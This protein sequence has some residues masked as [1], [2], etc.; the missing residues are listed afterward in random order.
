M[1]K[2]TAIAGRLSEHMCSCDI[3]IFHASQLV[4]SN[5]LCY[6]TGG[7][8]VCAMDYTNAMI[9]WDAVC[10]RV[11]DVR[12]ERL[13]GNNMELTEESPFFLFISGKNTRVTIADKPYTLGGDTMLSLIHI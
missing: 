10:V 6:N 8:E 3:Q 2:A 4:P 1:R 11:T 12:H 5:G 13:N 7:S 9:L